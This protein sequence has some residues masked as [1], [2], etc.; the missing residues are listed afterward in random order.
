LSFSSNSQQ[1]YGVNISGALPTAIEKFKQK[2]FVLKTSMDM[3]VIMRGRIVNQD[4]QLFIFVTPKTKT[5]Y[6]MVI[7]FDELNSFDGLYT[8]YVKMVRTISEKYGEPDYVEEK[9]ITP[10]E[11][12]D[13]YELTAIA[14]EKCLYSTTWLYKNNLNV[15]V[16]ISKY[17]QLKVTY[18]NDILS[19]QKDKEEELLKSNIY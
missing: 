5:V 2:G 14:V 4:V 6:K 15:Q 16:Q 9:F 10:Y 13:G 18:E 8:Q 11:L 12:G 17:K 7:Y 3:G 1:F 19:E